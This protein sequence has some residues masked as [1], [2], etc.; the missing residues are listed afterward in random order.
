MLELNNLF[1]GSGKPPEASETPVNTSLQDNAK[2]KDNSFSAILDANLSDRAAAKSGK[3]TDQS[4]EAVP[5]LDVTGE[6]EKR[7]L[8]GGTELVLGGIE[9][10]QDV[11]IDYAQAQGLDVDLIEIL[12]ADG[13]SEG[14]DER[15]PLLNATASSK[16]EDLAK[17]SD[18]VGEIGHITQKLQNTPAITVADSFDSRIISQR[19]ITQVA[20]V[21]SVAIT[22]LPTLKSSVISPVLSQFMSE[23]FMQ[24]AS[25]SVEKSVATPEANQSGQIQGT[26]NI[27]T[28]VMPRSLLLDDTPKAQISKASQVQAPLIQNRATNNNAEV[29]SA[30]LAPQASEAS[31]SISPQMERGVNVSLTHVSTGADRPSLTADRL[32]MNARLQ[33]TPETSVT[34]FR[35]M[36][37]SQ[38]VRVSPDPLPKSGQSKT[39]KASSSL[40]E[41]R[42]TIPGLVALTQRNINTS[43]QNLPIAKEEGQNSLSTQASS[44]QMAKRPEI[45][46]NITGTLLKASIIQSEGEAVSLPLVKTDGRPVS[47]SALSGFKSD[48]SPPLTNQSTSIRSLKPSQ[49]LSARANE[50]TAQLKTA[51]TVLTANYLNQ[52]KDNFPASAAKTAQVVN[53]PQSSATILTE[54][55]INAVRGDTAVSIPKTAQVVNTPQSSATIFTETQLNAVRGDTAVSIPKTAQVVNTPQSSATILT[56]TQLNVVRGDTAVSIPKTAQVVNTPQS[57]ATILTETQLNVVRGDTAVSIPKTTQVVNTPQSFETVPTEAHR[58]GIKSDITASAVTMRADAPNSPMRGFVNSDIVSAK[59]VLGVSKKEAYRTI[60]SPDRLDVRLQEAQQPGQLAKTKTEVIEPVTFSLPLTMS[61]EMKRSES[62]NTAKTVL[63]PIKLPAAAESTIGTNVQQKFGLGKLA[64]GLQ[65]E[66]DNDLAMQSSSGRINSSDKSNDECLEDTGKSDILRRQDQYTDLSRRLTDALG[67]RLSAQI[68]RGTWQVEMELH[69]RS[70]GRIEIQLEMK[71]GELEAQFNA[72]KAATR[73]LIQE[74]LPRLRAELEQHGTDSAYV[75]VGQQNQDKP[76]GK[77]TGSDQ[78]HNTLDSENED[79]EIQSLT[80]LN[81]EDKQGLDIQV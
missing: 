36:K 10:S 9:P 17:P 73:E 7:T 71:N 37:V 63:P 15:N 41:S 80:G 5:P 13:G 72:S 24:A 38:P 6:L 79:Q 42:A 62:S 78:P 58:N 27:E 21:R 40:L 65:K 49:V 53:T 20:A 2:S 67:R 76:D 23:E 12:M 33:L 3:E 47:N 52:T 48:S 11:I 25:M 45:Q 55:Q 46:M 64:E 75:G 39:D 26:K 1:L 34:P 31:Q 77:P 70:L 61:K 57:S 54:T 44:S 50:V 68:A 69:P 4:G 51:Q 28:Q 74:G 43:T 8:N 30:K 60:Q 29:I 32:L 81:N 66:S 14:A 22:D 56:E 18:L 16:F 59:S 19:A 35:D